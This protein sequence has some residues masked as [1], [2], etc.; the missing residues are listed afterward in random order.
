MIEGQ[1]SWIGEAYFL[2]HSFLYQKMKRRK[3]KEQKRPPAINAEESVRSASQPNTG[4]RKALIRSRNIAWILKREARLT[5]EIWRFWSSVCKGWNKAP[6]PW[7][8][9]M[10]IAEQTGFLED[11]RRKQRSAGKRKQ[12]ETMPVSPSFLVRDSDRGLIIAKIWER[13]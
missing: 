6:N 10:H 12:Q 1:G 7:M 13:I 3:P 8:P 9:K 11:A 2:W 5:E 4:L